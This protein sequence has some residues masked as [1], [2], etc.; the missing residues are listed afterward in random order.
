MFISEPDMVTEKMF[1]SCRR[2]LKNY[3]PEMM[4]CSIFFLS[5][6]FCLFLLATLIRGNFE[7]Q[8][9]L[10]SQTMA[11]AR[12]VP[13]HLAHNKWGK[14]GAGCRAVISSENI[15]KWPYLGSQHSFFSLSHK[16]LPWPL[17][18]IHSWKNSAT[19][20]FYI[21][22]SCLITWLYGIFMWLKSN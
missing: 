9:R 13:S 8:L 5:P 2:F 4:G 11:I 16:P 18:W 7:T 21:Q 15:M 3:Q 19:L 12:S 10:E 1:A 14:Y 20:K 22:A 6:S 17:Q